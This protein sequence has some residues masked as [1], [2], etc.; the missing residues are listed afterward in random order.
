LLPDVPGDLVPLAPAA[1]GAWIG[2]YSS[3]RQPADL[4]RF[5]PNDARPEAFVSLTHVWERTALRPEDLVAAE[6]FRW[7]SVD[8]LEIQGWLYRGCEPARG[9]VAYVHGGPTSHSADRLNGQIQFFTSRGF[10]VLDPNYRGSTGFS[11]GFREA[12]KEDGWG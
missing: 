12:I 3:S 11:L 5:S 4:V 7:R 10:H 8:G 9:A 6:D 2:M 1:D